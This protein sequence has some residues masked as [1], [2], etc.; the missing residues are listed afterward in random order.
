MRK[1]VLAAAAACSLLSLAGCSSDNHAPD[2]G[3]GDLNQYGQYAS[4]RADDQYHARSQD[5]PDTKSK[6][7]TEPNNES[8]ASKTVAVAEGDSLWSISEDQLGEGA[9]PAEILSYVDELYR[10]NRD[11]VGDDPNLI[12]PGQALTLP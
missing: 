3:S 12:F 8:A 11:A 2:Q 9:T 5:G 7:R 4:G 1:K 6:N 10:A